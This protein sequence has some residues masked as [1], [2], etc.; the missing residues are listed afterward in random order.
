MGIKNLHH[1]LKKKCPNVYSEVPISKYAFKKIA[2]DISIFMCKYK[3]TQGHSF[4]DS[5][6]N[7]ISILRYNEVHFVFV[8]DSKAPPEKDLE[9]KNRSELREKNKLRVQNLQN[10]WF[11]YKDSLQLK[12]NDILNNDDELIINNDI[13][14]NFINK[15]YVDHQ[16]KLLLIKYI[17]QEILKLQNTLLTIRT[18]DF[19]LTKEFFKAC[20]I[21]FVDAEG[22]AE[23]TCCA[24]AKQGFVTAVLTEDTDVLAYGVPYMLHKMNYQQQ[25]WIEVDYKGIL[26]ELNMTSEQFLDFCILCSTDYNPN[27]FRMG[28]EKAFK[29]L[30][31]YKSIDK[32]PNNIDISNLNHIRVRQIFQQSLTFPFRSISY[33]GFPNQSEFEK[34]YFFNN[35]KFDIQTFYNSFTKSIFHEFPKEDDN[36]F[37]NKSFENNETII[38]S[39]LLLLN[40]H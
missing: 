25:S 28:P 6:L 2:I 31:E 14:K 8:Y 29:I 34:L 20:N 35:C 30:S 33:C 4:M 32:I 36:T 21:P 23:A 27:I 12:E 3:T 10:Q 37:E 7:L 40:H 15:I 18:E 19:L 22:E 24:L 26:E 38:S 1:F 16:D 5:F 13:L 39:R 11:Q 9:R 17:D